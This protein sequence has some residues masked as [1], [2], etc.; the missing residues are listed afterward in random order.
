MVERFWG[1]MGYVRVA[2]GALYVVSLCV[3]GIRCRVSLQ[4]S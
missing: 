4:L 3:C 1:E 2:F